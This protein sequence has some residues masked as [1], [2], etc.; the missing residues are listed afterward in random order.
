MNISKHISELIVYKILQWKRT[1]SLALFAPIQASYSRQAWDRLGI[2]R[3]IPCELWLP[4]HQLCG[5]AQNV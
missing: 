4:H 5:L 2:G 3:R 1:F